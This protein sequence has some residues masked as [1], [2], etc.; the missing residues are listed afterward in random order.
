MRS[1]PKGLVRDE[2][3]AA[4][5]AATADMLVERRRDR[6]IEQALTAGSIGWFV[7]W[8]LLVLPSAL[9]SGPTWASLVKPSLLVLA[10]IAL[11][12]SLACFTAV[13]VLAVQR[14]RRWY[15]ARASESPRGT[16]TEAPLADLDAGV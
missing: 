11:L 3:N 5:Q 14:T 2:L 8:V 13:I 1:L 9:P 4:I 16:S 12:F 6:R 7:T 15:L 10:L